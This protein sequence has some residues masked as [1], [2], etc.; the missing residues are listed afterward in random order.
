ML[1]RGGATDTDVP[2]PPF[3]S[4]PR[5]V[6]TKAMDFIHSFGF[7]V[8]GAV[9]PPSSPQSDR[10][11]WE[12]TSWARRSHGKGAL[13]LVGALAAI[14]CFQLAS[15]FGMGSLRRHRRGRRRHPGWA[16][17]EGRGLEAFAPVHVT[18]DV[19][20]GLTTVDTERM[21]KFAGFS[22]F[23]S[24]VRVPVDRPYGDRGAGGGAAIPCLWSEAFQRNV[25]LI[26]GA[27]PSYNSACAHASCVV[28]H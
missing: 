16:A 15:L 12:G 13:L 17:V 27:L 28:P 10:K 6:L 22:N 18:E 25:Y 1:R 9:S 20:Q 19:E 26:P 7:D 4:S 3:P 23:T 21:A 14:T 2:P 11:R 5:V 24:F 8:A